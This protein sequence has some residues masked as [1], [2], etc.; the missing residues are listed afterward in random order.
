MAPKC[1]KGACH[2]SHSFVCLDTPLALP[3]P[4]PSAF[5]L[6][7]PSCSLFQKSPYS[8]G[9]WQCQW[10]HLRTPVSRFSG[11]ICT[12]DHIIIIIIR[13]LGWADP[14]LGPAGCWT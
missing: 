5:P 1:L 12:R 9:Q 3:R 11:P 7:T 14:T 6:P 4:A 10:V 8:S 13:R 2:H